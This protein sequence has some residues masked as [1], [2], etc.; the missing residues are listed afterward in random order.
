[1]NWLYELGALGLTA[2]GLIHAVSRE[3]WG[4]AMVWGALFCAA[5]LSAVHNEMKGV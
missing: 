1:M 4:A 3:Q 2:A 5:F